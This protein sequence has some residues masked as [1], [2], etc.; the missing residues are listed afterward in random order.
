MN[1]INVAGVDVGSSSVKS[2]VFRLE[3]GHETLLAKRTER[4]RR[5]EVGLV[6][7]ENF[8]A[9]LEDAHLKRDDLAYTASTGEGE[10]VSFRTGHFFG[11]TTH[12]RGA[13]F[14]MPRARCVIDVGALHTRAMVV[15]E[16][17]KVL[18]S[19]MTGQCA[20]GTGQF[21]ENISRYLGVTLREVAE[22]SLRATAPERVSAICAV[23]A[24][25]D[26]I[27]MVSRGIA[28]ADILKG[29]HL[30]MADRLVKLARSIKAPAPIAVTGG[31]A[32][33]GGLVAA[34]REVQVDKEDAA[35]VIVHEDS[36]YAGDRSEEHTSELQSQR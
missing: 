24:E 23:L 6:V 21:L 16:R 14:L 1:A 28:A 15:D 13:I 12:A 33:D 20:S 18:Q 36:I 31:L 9:L 32:L 5:R 7:E 10:L 35:E 2:V 27:N 34:L 3:N 11:M 4:I 29:V 26:V 8:G 30:S 25:T 17:S 22:L 19:A